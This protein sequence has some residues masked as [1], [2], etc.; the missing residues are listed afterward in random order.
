MRNSEFIKKYGIK[1][2]KSIVDGVKENL[3][4]LHYN[5]EI[6]KYKVNKRK[7]QVEFYS[8]GKFITFD[9]AE[10]FYMSN[11][12]IISVIRKMGKEV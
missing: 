5:K 6:P 9:I 2:F 4:I 1:N 7:K 12:E 8:N 3:I 11:K 10:M